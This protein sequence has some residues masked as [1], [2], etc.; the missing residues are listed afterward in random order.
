M[1]HK[2]FTYL[3]RQMLEIDWVPPLDSDA[4]SL[5]DRCDSKLE[6]MFIAGA[7]HFIKTMQE[8]FYGGKHDPSL[9]LA[10]ID[11][12]GR[13]YQGIWYVEP[14]EGWYIFDDD[15]DCELNS[16]PS[17]VA[18]V[19]Q[20]KSPEKDIT[21]DIGI[22]YGDDNGSPTWTFSKAIEIDGYA[23]HKDRRDKDRMR[24]SGLSYPVLRFAE[25]NTDIRTWFRKVVEFEAGKSI[26]QESVA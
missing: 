17:A 25:E 19:P 18:F 12:N 14:W 9:H 5:L 20:M 6:V 15:E 16:G 2:N 11:F 4:L 23:V 21:H 24:D 3:C 22:F 1:N 13:A 7:F 26:S 10:N 8:N